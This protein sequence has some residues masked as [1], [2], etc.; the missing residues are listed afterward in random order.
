MP[1]ERAYL[2]RFT[3]ELGWVDVGRTF[4][5]DLLTAKRSLADT[6]VGGGE[7]AL[8]ELP[9]AAIAELVMLR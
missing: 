1:E 2:D 9:D 8:N 6:G 5:G 7:M 4:A 3:D